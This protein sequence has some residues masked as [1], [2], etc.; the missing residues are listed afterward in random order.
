MLRWY[1]LCKIFIRETHVREKG[2]GVREGMMRVWFLGERVGKEEDRV[3]TDSDCSTPLRK[4][5]SHQQKIHE[6][7]SIVI[8]VLMLQKWTAIIP[9]PGAAHE[10]HGLIISIVVEIGPLINASCGRRSL[11]CINTAAIEN[12]KIYSVFSGAVIYV[13]IV[14]EKGQYSQHV[15]MWSWVMT[16]KVQVQQ[17]LLE[18][19]SMGVQSREEL[20]RGS[21]RSQIIT[22]NWNTV[23]N[24]H[25]SKSYTENLL[26]EQ[27][28]CASC[29]VTF[30]KKLSLINLSYVLK[31]P[32]LQHLY[33]F[34][35]SRL[36]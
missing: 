23:W 28:L 36:I 19:L 3:G 18:E 26:L 22:E 35:L 1:Y 29:L 17:V 12:M 32:G 7:K 4:I 13:E 16:W 21:A 20:A 25:L 8:G 15:D 30:I 5:W 33:S 11:W 31:S 27:N 6:P 9:T 14:K 10:K 34:Q 2:E 24:K